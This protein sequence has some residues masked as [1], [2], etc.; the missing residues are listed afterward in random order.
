M[1][2]LRI[3][4]LGTVAA[5]CL[6]FAA[7]M[8][9]DKAGSHTTLGDRVDTAVGAIRQEAGAVADQLR[10][11]IEQARVEVDKLGTNGRIYARLHWDKTLAGSTFDI[12][13]RDGGRVVLRGAVP[14]AS[15]RSRAVE[16]ARNTVG[17]DQV[18][19]ELKVAATAR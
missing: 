18:T 8:L 15:A 9:A 2:V 1:R 11:G 6:L 19:D 4:V 16:L 3:L 10:R 12:E 5:S 7:A 17:V 13:V 14:D